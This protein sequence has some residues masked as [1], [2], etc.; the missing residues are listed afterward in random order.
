[1]ATEA[2]GRTTS[3]RH[4]DARRYPGSNSRD[5]LALIAS[6]R[7]V[8]REEGRVGLAEWTVANIITCLRMIL[9]FARHAGYTRND[10][11][12][13]LSPEELPRQRPREEF[14]ARVL[15]PSEIERL[16]AATTPLY[17]YAV[18]VLAYSGL[19]VSEAAGLTWADVDLVERVLHVRKQL[20]PLRLGEEPRRVRTKSHA[21]VR[22]VPLLDRAYDALLAQLE[23]EQ[24]KGLGAEGDFMFTSATGR[25][26]DR[27]RLSKRGV[28]SGGEEG[29][30]RSCDG[31]ASRPQPLPCVRGGGEGWHGWGPSPEDCLEQSHETLARVP[32]LRQ[33]SGMTP[34][35]SPP[36]KMIPVRRPLSPEPLGRRIDLPRI[37]GLL[38]HARA[39]SCREFRHR[40]PHVGP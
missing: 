38:L 37:G 14:E 16:I 13:T 28:M 9:R 40:V 5:M 26:L 25:P 15:R 33:R 34:E 24:A 36:G 32:R 10:P 22:A 2:T 27:H 21:S 12:S 4:S 20:A 31:S 18:T 35:H 3:S 39:V 7:S 19:R 30:H 8:P 29:W 6:L 11:F 23:S 17:R 1:M